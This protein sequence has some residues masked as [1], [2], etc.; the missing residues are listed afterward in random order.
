MDI[1]ALLASRAGGGRRRA[2]PAAAARGR[3]ARAA[4]RGHALRGVRRRQA[5][6]SDPRPHGVPGGRGSDEAALEPACALEL[7]H[8]YSLVHDDL[9]AMDDDIAAPRPADRPR[10]L[11]RGAG[12]PRRRRAAHRGIRRARAVPRGRVVRRRGV[13]RRAGFSRPRSV[14]PGMVGGQVED[15]EATG[16]APDAAQARAHPPREDGRAAGGLGRARR[17][18]RRGRRRIA[19]RHSPPSVVD[20]ACSSRSPMIS[21]TSRARRRVSARARART[22]PRAS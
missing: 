19:G 14:P 21:S 7:I 8:T 10:G 11:R 20:S 2:G 12:D 18:A 15:L 13:P 4:A 6:A 9:P 22:R 3:L 16:A 17:A 5:G 1:A